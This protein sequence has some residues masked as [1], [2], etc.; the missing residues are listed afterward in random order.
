MAKGFLKA[1]NIK[2]MFPNEWKEWSSYLLSRDK[3]CQFINSGG[4][5]CC[6]KKFLHPHHI[7]KKSN[8]LMLSFDKNNGIILCRKHHLY[9]HR[10]SL[11]QIYAPTFFKTAKENGE[12]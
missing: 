10:N 1:S 3:C 7:I 9:I 5:K 4:K 6:A 11:E 8:N 12:K 2:K